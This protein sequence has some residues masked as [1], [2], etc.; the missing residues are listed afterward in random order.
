MGEYQCLFDL[1]VQL[2][3]YVI[4]IVSCLWGQIKSGWMEHYWVTS[5][6][7]LAFCRAILLS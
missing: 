2:D 6:F 1:F 7:D 3:S 5:L 4:Y